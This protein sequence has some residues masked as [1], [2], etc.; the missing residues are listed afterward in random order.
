MPY[1]YSLYGSS[2]EIK[3]VGKEREDEKYRE[4]EEEEEKSG[5]LFRK[6]AEKERRNGR[7]L[8]LKGAFCTDDLVTQQS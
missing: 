8:S 4:K 1:R 7:S 2:I 6:A 5:Y 3:G